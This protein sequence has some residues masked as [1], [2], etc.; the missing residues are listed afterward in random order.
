MALSGAGVG[1]GK[2][3]S[4]GFNGYQQ[5]TARGGGLSSEDSSPTS[6]YNQSR[7]EGATGQVRTL[8]YFIEM[9]G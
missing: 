6:E 8:T 3:R 5:T 1:G 9:H 4:E 2:S 7:S